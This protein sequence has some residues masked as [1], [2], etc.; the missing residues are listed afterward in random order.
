MRVLMVTNMYPCPERPHYGSFIKSQ[1]D[2]IRE[3]E[4]DVDV[5]F[6]R[7]YKNKLFYFTSIV[8]LWWRC[9]TQRYDIVHAHYGLS[10]IVARMQLRYPVI[11]SYCGDDL[12]GHAGKEG[13]PTKSSLV[14]AWLNKQL[15]RFVPAVIVKSNVM[16]DL[17]PIKENINVV[18]NGVDFHTFKPM[19]KSHCREHLGLDNNVIYVLFPYDSK[20]LRKNYKGVKEAVDILKAKIQQR[21]EILTVSG[22]LNSE[23]PLYMNAADVMVLA[24]FWEGSPNAVKEALACNTK[25]VS[26]DVGDVKELIENVSNCA[27][28]DGTVNDMADK[29]E[30]VLSEDENVSSRETIRHLELNSI[31]KK[32]IGI[33]QRVSEKNNS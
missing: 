10:G 24:S 19:E 28:C 15:S 18:P 7:G 14:S 4:V 9:I 30:S 25:V 27:I 5:L 6:I 33:Y 12:Y 32:V 22:K 3:E 11:V 23:I 8:S 21:V 20:R 29:L 26:V 1:I 13:K 31:A 17:L 16:V 2:S